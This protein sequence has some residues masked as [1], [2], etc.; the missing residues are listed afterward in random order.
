MCSP[1]AKTKQGNLKQPTRQ[2]V[3]DWASRAWKEIEPELLICSFLVC[4]IS[5]A[6]KDG[7]DK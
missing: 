6:S 1:R 7:L 2:D 5:N 4:G 3:I